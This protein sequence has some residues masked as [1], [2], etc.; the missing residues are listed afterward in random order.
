MNDN[1]KRQ[2]VSSFYDADSPLAATEE[3][4]HYFHPSETES[5]VPQNDMLIDENHDIEKLLSNLDDLNNLEFN[6]E[7]NCAG[8]M[9]N[10]NVTFSF[11]VAFSCFL[12]FKFK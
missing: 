8:R 5:Y 4:T 10:E 12:L 2:R 11:F 1:R 3:S 6:A 9:L 7:G